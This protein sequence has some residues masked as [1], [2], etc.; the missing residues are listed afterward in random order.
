ME[1]TH[2][3]MELLLLFYGMGLSIVICLLTI[4]VAVN[5][6]ENIIR[7]LIT[8]YP[9]IINPKNAASIFT[10]MCKF[11]VEVYCCTFFVLFLFSFSHRFYPILNYI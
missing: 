11:I 7:Y 2:L 10:I 3:Q 9:K 8:L 5:S 1:T 6:Q 4:W